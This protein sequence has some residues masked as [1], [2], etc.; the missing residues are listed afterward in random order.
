MIGATTLIQKVGLAISLPGGPTRLGTLE[1]GTTLLV[2]ICLKLMNKLMV[3]LQVPCHPLLSVLL[4][5]Q[6]LQDFQGQELM[7]L[8][9]LGQAWQDFSWPH[10]WQHSLLL[11]ILVVLLKAV[12]TCSMTHFLQ[13]I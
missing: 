10:S 13:K 1:H 8:L 6:H 4:P 5:L 9:H 11:A 3:V 2:A 12:G 7:P